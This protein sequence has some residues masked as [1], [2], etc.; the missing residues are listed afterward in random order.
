MDVTLN[1]GE[2]SAFRRVLLA[3]HD[4]HALVSA[5]V[6]VALS[7]L[8]P[9]DVILTGEGDTQGYV[10][11]GVD[12]PDGV[13]PDIGPKVCDGLWN[14]GLE[15]FASLPWDAPDVA[16]ARSSGERDE[17]RLNFATSRHTVVGVPGNAGR[18]HCRGSVSVGPAI[19][20]RSFAMS[21]ASR[22]S[23]PMWSKVNSN[24]KAP[25]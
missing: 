23:A 17:L 13:L 9:C 24:G 7:V 5:D 15:H 25:V 22:A 19:T 14:T 11:R 2:Q 6:A 20:S 4:P 1:P 16:A 21:L 12:Y 3:D 10:L 8:L 18:W